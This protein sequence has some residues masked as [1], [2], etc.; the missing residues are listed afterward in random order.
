MNAISRLC[1]SLAAAAE[2]VAKARVQSYLLSM[3]PEWTERH[4]YSWDS[5]RG[6]IQ[7][8]PWRQTSE[9]PAHEPEIRYTVRELNDIGISRDGIEGAVRFGKPEES[10]DLHQHDAAA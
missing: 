1:K 7:N 10:T 5:L 6:G 3:G 4:G 2:A 8:W 9:Q